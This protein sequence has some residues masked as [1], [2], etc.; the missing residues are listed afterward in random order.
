MKRSLVLEA[1]YEAVSDSLEWGIDC[2]DGSHSYHIDGICA[3][4]DILLKKIDEDEK[5]QLEKMKSLSSM[6]ISCD[7]L[8]SSY[9]EAGCCASH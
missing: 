1:A 6:I 7:N 8:A 2:K 9:D 5:E 4:V 3:V